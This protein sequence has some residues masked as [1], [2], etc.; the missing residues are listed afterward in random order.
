M[1]RGGPRPNSGGSRPGAGRKRLASKWSD[2][3]KASLVRAI[4]KKQ[5]ETGQTVQ[6]VLLDIYYGDETPNRDRVAIFKALQDGL[7]ERSSFKE[8]EER[9]FIYA[10]LVLP[11]MKDDPARIDH[12]AE[13]EQ[14]EKLLN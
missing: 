1:G 12:D 6:E 10:P 14:P 9:K 7:V 2:A 13:P 11:T 4:K 5:K 3:F 8:V